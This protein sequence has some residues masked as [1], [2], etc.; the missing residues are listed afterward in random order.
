MTLQVTTPTVYGTVDF[1]LSVPCI[2]SI[3]DGVPDKQCISKMVEMAW[4]WKPWGSLPCTLDI[5]DVATESSI[6]F[7]SL[8]GCSLLSVI[9]RANWFGVCL[10]LVIM[11]E[12]LALLPRI[13]CLN[14]WSA[15]ND[16][17]FLNWVGFIFAAPDIGLSGRSNKPLNNITHVSAIGVRNGF[18]FF[19]RAYSQLTE[20][21]AWGWLGWYY[22]LLA[23]I[24][25][26]T[27]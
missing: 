8:F 11:F 16:L 12:W 22:S 9:Q 2:N 1:P 14:F 26:S 27:S 13:V 20:S 5:S 3:D 18:K 6:S 21:P 10:L 23:L 19:F 4:S 7:I 15:W 17:F 25:G 24:P